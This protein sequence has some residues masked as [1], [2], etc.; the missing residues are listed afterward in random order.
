MPLPGADEGIGSCPVAIVCRHGASD[1]FRPP[2]CEPVQLRRH[3]LKCAEAIRVSR[4]TVSITDVVPAVPGD[5]QR[6]TWRKG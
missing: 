2:G 6:A 5:V 1:P 3:G 4:A